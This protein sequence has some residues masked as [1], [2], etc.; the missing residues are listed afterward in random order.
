MDLPTSTVEALGVTEI[1]GSFAS[2]VMVAF[3]EILSLTFAVISAVPALLPVILPLLSTVATDG[4]LDSH[5]TEALAPAGERVY[6]QV[7]VPSTLMVV[8]LFEFKVMPSTTTSAALTVAEP[9]ALIVCSPEGVEPTGGV[10]FISQEKL[11]VVPALA[12]VGTV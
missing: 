11:S 1:E 7:V 3:A 2:T 9:V 12:V 5:D 8:T 10:Y 4:F 6:P